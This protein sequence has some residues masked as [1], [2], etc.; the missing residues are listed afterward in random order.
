MIDLKVE[1]KPSFYTKVNPKIVA[2]AT[3]AMI[4]NTT[5]RAEG[6]CKKEAPVDTG[7]LR[8]SHSSDIS[9]M[10]G[11]VQNSAEYAVYVVHG[12]SKMEAN[13]YP[14]RVA[15]TLA[16]EKYMSKTFQSELKKRGAFQ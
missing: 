6:D 1:I 16:S 13:N 10:E 9:E 12:T 11:L 14:E 5:L 3:A 15:N 4:K 8:R 2:E 7:N